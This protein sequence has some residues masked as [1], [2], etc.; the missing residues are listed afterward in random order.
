MPPQKA[1][2][3]SIS[4][5][6]AMQAPPATG[7][8]ESQSA[9][10]GINAPLHACHL[11][12]L[13]PG[14]RQC[15]GAHA[16]K[17]EPHPHAA[18]GGPLQRQRHG[19]CTAVQVKDVGLELDLRARL[20]NGCDQG[21]KVGVPALDEADLVT[22]LQCRHQT[23]VSIQREFGHQRQMVGHALPDAA[24]RNHHTQGIQAAS[25]HMVQVG[26]RQA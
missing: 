16:V 26:Q 22:I 25:I 1:S 21:S 4:A 7:N 24:S 2:S 18:Q 20:V 19:L 17:H 10:R 14:C 8:Q 9:Q 12:T 15:R 6:L 5:Q 11:E 23:H 3:P 13:G